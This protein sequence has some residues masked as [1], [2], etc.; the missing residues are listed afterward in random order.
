M[1]R[2]WIPAGAL[3]GV[4]VA[5]LMALGPLTDSLTS[6]VTFAPQVAVTSTVPAK[7]EQVSLSIDQGTAGS[8]QTAALSNKRGGQA[9]TT[10]A[11]VSGDSGSV[12]F[13]I[14]ATAPHVAATVTPTPSSSSTASTPPPKAT[15]KPTTKRPASIGGSSGPNGDT[16][17]ASGGNGSTSVG[18][19]SGTPGND[20]P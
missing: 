1:N 16:G 14:P 18:A 11:P 7:A 15:A 13:R 9:S 8:V 2:A 10:K 4:S 17:L 20:A 12:G 6:P 5:G 19:Q 3:A